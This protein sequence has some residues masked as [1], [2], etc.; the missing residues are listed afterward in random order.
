MSCVLP[1]L[2]QMPSHALCDCCRVGEEATAHLTRGVFL[3]HWHRCTAPGPGHLTVVCC[4]ILNN[5]SA[6]LECSCGVPVPLLRRHAQDAHEALDMLT[7][8]TY[9]STEVST[10]I[11]IPTKPMKG[12]RHTA[13]SYYSSTADL[14]QLHSR[15]SRNSNS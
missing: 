4:H 9:L 1:L 13:Q 15:T 12:I 10:Y 3:L 6:C 11:H 7:A 5:P 14:L 2:K 8:Y